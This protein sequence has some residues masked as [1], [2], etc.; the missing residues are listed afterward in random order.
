MVD[1]I[2]QVNKQIV[3]PGVASDF[4]VLNVNE[5]HFNNNGAATE[6][7]ETIGEGDFVIVAYPY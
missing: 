5:L 4:D 7:S 2:C 1:G 6:L 3:I